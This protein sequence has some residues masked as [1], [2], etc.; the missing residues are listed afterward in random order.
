MWN[1]SGK[2]STASSWFETGLMNTD[3]SAWDGAKW[4]G[5]ETEDLVLQSHYLS[6][7]KVHYKLQ[8]EKKT[9]TSK[10]SFILGAN[11]PRLMDKNKKHLQCRK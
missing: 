2:K 8:L 9:K 5:T 1:E 10:A 3:I 11:D 4:I 7:Y 6:V